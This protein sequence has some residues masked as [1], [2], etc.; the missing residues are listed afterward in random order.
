MA[1]VG[2]AK[3]FERR[4]ETGN[5][6]MKMPIRLVSWF[7]VVVCVVALFAPLPLPVSLSAVAVPTIGGLGAVDSA[8]W[9]CPSA[10]HDYPPLS[11]PLELRP[12]LLR[13][14]GSLG[15][16]HANGAFRHLRQTDL[17]LDPRFPT[18]FITWGESHVNYQRSS[19]LLL[20]IFLRAFLFSFSFLFF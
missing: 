2:G 12:T 20:P 13:T 4:R 16:N 17:V 6:G 8:M 5:I 18:I 15:T 7:H 9:P 19:S 11:T 14:V 10:S 3:R 1:I